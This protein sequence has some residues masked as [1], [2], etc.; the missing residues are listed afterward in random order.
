MLVVV[1]AAAVAARTV[2]VEIVAAVADK[3]NIARALGM[4]ARKVALH[5]SRLPLCQSE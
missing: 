1:A 5:G 3:D 4:E 2:E